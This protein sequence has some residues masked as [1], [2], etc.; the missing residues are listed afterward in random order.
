MDSPSM[1]LGFA[2]AKDATGKDW[3]TI[4]HQ[5]ANMS[6]TWGIPAES[7]DEF[8][9]QFAH[10]LKDAAAQA[11]RQASGLVLPTDIPA[12]PV[13]LNKRQEAA[14]NLRHLQGRRRG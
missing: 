3:V 13:N 11:R 7:A 2:H 5:I 6:F 8:A 14:R 9:D 10:A 4:T 1:G 12:E